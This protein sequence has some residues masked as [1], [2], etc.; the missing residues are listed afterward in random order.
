MKIKSFSENLLS[1]SGSGANN[2]RFYKI[3]IFE[4]HL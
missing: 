1:Q 3:Q 2:E 4:M